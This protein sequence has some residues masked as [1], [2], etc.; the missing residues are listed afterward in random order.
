[1]LWEEVEIDKSIQGQFSSYR[2]FGGFWVTYQEVELRD[3]ERES[4]IESYCPCKYSPYRSTYAKIPIEVN[5]IISKCLQ[6]DRLLIKIT[7]I[8]PRDYR[9]FIS[10]HLR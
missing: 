9:L 1:M 6:C 4:I 10:E 2:R 3:D 5:N 7:G 8:A